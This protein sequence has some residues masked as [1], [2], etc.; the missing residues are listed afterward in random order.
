MLL[1]IPRG[2]DREFESRYCMLP[3]SGE[4]GVWSATW[5]SHFQ[6]SLFTAARP[7]GSRS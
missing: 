3:E 5:V 6:G 2:E 4:H 7:I 1:R